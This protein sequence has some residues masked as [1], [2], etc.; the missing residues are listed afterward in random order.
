M[1]QSGK[2]QALNT[3]AR[4]AIPHMREA[5]RSAAHAE[6]LARVLAFSDGARWVVEE[7][8]PI[9]SFEWNDLTADGFTDLGAALSAVAAELRV[10]PMAS[11][12]LPPVLVLIS[13][14]QPTDDFEQGLAELMAEP[15]GQR[16]V[17]LAIAIGRDADQEALSRFIGNPAIPPMQA[18][19][20]EMLVQ[21]VRWASVVVDPVSQPGTLQAEQTV[22][23]PP[24]VPKEITEFTW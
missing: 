12:A 17:R 24:E 9:D 15:W 14:G 16:A 5:A 10:P 2:I 7:P 11:R 8:T 22:P 20:P 1:N 23:A 4:E 3:A 13:D 18:H 6:V 21:L 19:T